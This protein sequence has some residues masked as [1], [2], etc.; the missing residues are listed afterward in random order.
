MTRRKHPGRPVDGILLLDKP[1]GVSSNQ[2]LQRAKRLFGARKAG[3]TGNLDVM[4]SGMLPLCFGEATKFSGFL[5][6]AR[7]RYVATFKLG[8]QTDTGD[9]EGHIISRAPL[10][11]VD[12]E[13]VESVLERY[14]GEIFQI[15]PM[16]SAIKR[17]GQP[18][19][20]LARR[21]IE[22]PRD[23]RRVEIYALH[24]IALD[25]DELEVDIRCSKGTYVRTLAEDI[26]R[27]LGCLAHVCRLRRTEVEPYAGG[28]VHFD[29]LEAARRDGEAGLDALLLPMD[30]A[31]VSQPRIVLAQDSM[32][33]LRRGQPVLVP[34]SPTCGLI[35]IYGDSGEF[36]GIGEVLDDGRVAPKRMVKA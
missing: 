2:A 27:D 33:Y 19:Y 15:P 8:A 34:H 28:M 20:K 30:S 35:R 12:L 24:L 5:L 9:A 10:D 13:A 31:L 21:G 14:R 3:H 16:H 17:D 22:V 7:K 23:A 26:G 36:L 18:L 4:A 25:G 11:G 6:N 1:Q 29:T 32:F